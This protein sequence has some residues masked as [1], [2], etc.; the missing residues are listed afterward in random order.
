MKKKRKPNTKFN[1]IDVPVFSEIV[2]V[3]NDSITA[4]VMP[5]NNI[6]F[7]GK[8]DSLSD[9]TTT[10]LQEKYGATERT[11]VNGFLY[12][13]YQGEILADRRK[14]IED[15]RLKKEMQDLHRQG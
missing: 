11:R 14:R 15:E 4:T 9:I 6:I 8:T 10:L 3:H 2:F 1:D 13:M 12:W 7:N 5:D